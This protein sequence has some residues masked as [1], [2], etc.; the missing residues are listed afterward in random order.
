MSETALP[1]PALHPNF[2]VL[3]WA[4]VAIGFG[5][6]AKINAF[7]GLVLVCGY[8]LNHRYSPIDSLGSVGALGALVAAVA[9]LLGAT[10][11]IIWTY[12][13]WLVW[14]LASGGAASSCEQYSACLRRTSAGRRCQG[15]VGTGVQ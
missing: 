6:A 15:G 10:L 3:S 1:A 11:F 8:F 12:P 4:K 7:A 9:A 13:G 14:A 2:P 5:R